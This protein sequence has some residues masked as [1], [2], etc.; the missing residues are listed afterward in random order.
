M[1]ILYYYED[2]TLKEIGEVLQVTES[3]ISQLHT[4]A[5]LRLRSKLMNIKKSMVKVG[6]GPPSD[7]KLIRQAQGGPQGN[8]VRGGRGYPGIR[9]RSR[10]PRSR[11]PAEGE[12]EARGCRSVNSNTRSS[13]SGK[14]S[15]L[16]GKPF[17][18]L[19][20]VSERV[21]PLR[22]GSRKPSGPA[23]AP[24]RRSCEA[25]PTGRSR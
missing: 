17:K 23:P 25:T 2:L 21:C 11:R 5:I 20:S 14:R 22:Y 1:L 15:F 7:E 13:K 19:V 8:K 9:S 24:S 18:I 12:L 3:R 6:G 16:G 4:K 10:P